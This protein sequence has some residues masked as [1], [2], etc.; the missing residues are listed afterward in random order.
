MP[1]EQTASGAQVPCISLLAD[2][3]IRLC[4]DI[5][6]LPASSQQTDISCKAAAL[7]GRCQAVDAAIAKALD[8]LNPPLNGPAIQARRVLQAVTANAHDQ[9]ERGAR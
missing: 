6:A 2:D 1:N 7:H 5:E 4:W 3:A 8:L 9:P